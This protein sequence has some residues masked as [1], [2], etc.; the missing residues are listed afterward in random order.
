MGSKKTACG[1]GID[2]GPIARAPEAD[3][4]ARM[5]LAKTPSNNRKD[6]KTGYHQ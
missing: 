1:L 4:V 6:D 3:Q 2:P 5:T